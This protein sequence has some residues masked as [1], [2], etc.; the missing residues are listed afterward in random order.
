MVNICSGNGL[1]SSGNKPLPKQWL[2]NQWLFTVR[3][4]SFH[5]NTVLETSLTEMF[6][7]ITLSI[8]RFPAVSPVPLP[9]HN[10]PRGLLL[11]LGTI[12]GL[13]FQGTL[14]SHGGSTL[15]FLLQDLPIFCFFFDIL[16]KLT[17][18]GKISRSYDRLISTMGFPILIRCHPYIESGPW[19][20]TW[21]TLCLQMPQNL[22]VLGHQ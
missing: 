4:C 16:R 13:L 18:D 9:C 6:L 7:Q 1:L 19:T 15:V 2:P 11:L 21:F 8:F 20:P 22:G 12:M 10:V 17:N 5:Q 3:S 14:M